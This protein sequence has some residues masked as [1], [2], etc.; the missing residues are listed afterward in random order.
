VVATV[1]DDLEDDSE[2]VLVLDQLDPD[3]QPVFRRMTLNEYLHGDW[4]EA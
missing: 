2:D 4:D 1:V 3:G